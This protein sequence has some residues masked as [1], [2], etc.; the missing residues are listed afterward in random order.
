M[1]G[2]NASKVVNKIK[3]KPA[4]V[5]KKTVKESKVRVG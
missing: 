3:T 2:E 4:P 1:K 5:E